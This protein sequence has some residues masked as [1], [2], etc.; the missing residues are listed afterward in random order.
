MKRHLRERQKT[1]LTLWQ[2]YF[3][4]FLSLTAFPLSVYKFD[5]FLHFLV[6]YS[7]DLLSCFHLPARQPSFF[8]SVSVHYHH[9]LFR[10]YDLNL[11]EVMLRLSSPSRS[12]NSALIMTT[13]LKTHAFLGSAAR[14]LVMVVIHCK[15]LEARGTCSFW[16]RWKWANLINRA[17]F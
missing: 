5:T 13:E 2:L 15:A 10:W 17:D 7:S 8:S 6:V 3:L 14:P 9:H 1:G 16:L 4:C 12:T 11:E